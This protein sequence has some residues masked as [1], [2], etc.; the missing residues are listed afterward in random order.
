MSNCPTS[1]LICYKGKCKCSTSSCHGCRANLSS[2]D[3]MSQYQK[4]RL[5][6]NTVRVASSLYTMNLG[7]L[8][9]YTYP[10]NNL[11][12][13]W[14]QMSDRT[15]P[16]VQKTYTPR[17]GGSMGSDSTK[18][19][20]T[21]SRPG[22]Q[23]PGGIGCDIKHNSYDRYL[24]KLKGKSSLRR[25]VIP[26]NFGKKIPFNPAFPIY[27]NKTTNT[28]IIFNCKCPVNL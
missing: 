21:S 15:N 2:N 10:N 5:I 4:Q 17:S 26:T 6:Q 22:S 3:T 12:V 7:A 1:Q 8:T 23:S 25:G 24:N 28:G 14:N 18:N 27:G 16:S 19:T 9:A 20:V 11:K 13:N